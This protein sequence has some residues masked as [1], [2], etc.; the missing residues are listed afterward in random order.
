LLVVIAIIA[1]LIGLLLPAVQ[2]VREAAARIQCSNNLKQIGLAFHNCNNTFGLLP[3]AYGYFP[4]SSPS[5]G[6]G[7]GSGE[8][9]LLAFIEQD[10]IYKN[11]LSKSANLYSVDATDNAL[12]NYPGSKAV[13]TYVCPS[14][15]G[16]S[17]GLSS[18]SAVYGWGPWGA[19]C[20]GLNWQVF[21]NPTTGSWQ[22]NAQIPRDFVDGT[23][24][25]IIL[26]E[27]Y[28]SCGDLGNGPIGSLWGDNTMTT[29]SD[30]PAVQLPDGRPRSP[31]PLPDIPYLAH[32][33]SRACSRFNQPFLPNVPS[34]S[35]RRHI[36][37][38]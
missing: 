30:Y 37:G 34:C 21:G 9:H 12:G 5:P 17:N 25:T 3:P 14:D 26:A 38:A 15:P 35:P 16:V 27:K 22:K 33:R 11:S 8:F 24:N 2:K 10:N 28:A 36:R 20:Y 19:G 29:G 7:F 18:N 4:A 1:V 32:A 13:K 23:S 6:S 31:L